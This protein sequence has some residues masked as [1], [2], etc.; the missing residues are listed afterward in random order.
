MSDFLRELGYSPVRYWLLASGTFL[1][2]FASALLPWNSSEK[3]LARFNRPA[4]FGALLLAT[5]FAW[6]WPAIFHYKPVNP[7]EAQF[8]AGALTTIA[9]G[10]IWWIDP[11]TSGPLV[12]LPLTLPGLMGLPVDFTNGRLV[13]LLLEFGSV[14]L[15]YLTLRHVHGDQKS[16]LLIMPLACFMIFLWFWDFVPYCSELSPLFLSSLATWLCFTAFQPDGR[17]GSRLRL[18]LGG[19]ILGIIPFSKFQVLPLGAA[20]GLS[21]V[22][23]IFCQPA[24]NRKNCL[25]DLLCLGGG[26]VLGFGLMLASL[27]VSGHWDDVY[28]SYVVHNLHYTQARGLVWSESGYLLNYLTNLSWGFFPFHYGMLALLLVAQF[29]LRRANWR[30]VAF[31]GLLLISAYIAV[32]VP[33][34]LYPHYLLFLSFPLTLAVGLQFGYL[35][36]QQTQRVHAAL[37]GLLLCLG[38]AGQLV[39]RVRDDNSLHKLIRGENPRD[40][41]VRL[42]NRMKTNGDTLAVW[43]WRP[44]LYVETQLPQATREALTEAQL[45]DHP[46]RDYFRAR[47]LADLR[48]SQPAY[49]VDSIGPDDYLLTDRTRQCHETFPALGEYIAAEYSPLETTVSF[50]LYVK[51]TRLAG[52]K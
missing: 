10:T 12:V 1:L 4:I 23:W 21:T 14:F 2:W 28:Q 37:I 31:G 45:S 48:S 30:P 43:G 47:F 22:I 8:L 13:A 33:G 7:D 11:T 40:P 51:R 24:L 49:F 5:L 41:L 42:I 34:R 36:T 3:S 46:Q 27:R 32:L 39:D 17:V 38:S 9:R 44:E 29:G 52:Q 50:R 25:R 6:R 20:T 15:G 18:A 16:R 26:T 35:L 19:F